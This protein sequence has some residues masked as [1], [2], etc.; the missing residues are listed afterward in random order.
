MSTASED[1]AE[2]FSF[3]MTNKNELPKIASK[4][5]IIKKKISYLKNEI[6]K[7]DKNFK[8]D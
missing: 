2:I 5:I 4:D 7:I 3:L 8:F 1:M 6:R